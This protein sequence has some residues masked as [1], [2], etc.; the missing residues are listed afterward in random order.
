MSE[1]RVNL[2]AEFNFSCPEQIN[3][4]DTVLLIDNQQDMRLIMAHY[5]NKMGFK[6]VH[7]A[8]SGQDALQYLEAF[9]GN[10]SVI[11]CAMELPMMTGLDF[12]HEI[13]ED[14]RYNRGPFAITMMNPNREKIM[15]A[16]E[17]GVDEILVKPFSLKDILPKLNNAFKKFH[18]PYN[19]EKV[20]E[21]AKKHY[22]E[23]KYEDGEKIYKRLAESAAQS[24]RPIVGLARIA[25]KQGDHQKAMQLLAE[26][27]KRNVNYVHLY[28]LRGELFSE[29]NRLEEAIPQFRKAIEMSPL[30]PVRYESAAKIL[31]QQSKY[32]EA[33]DLLGIAIKNELNFP[34]LHHYLSQAFYA[35]KDFKRAIKHIRAALSIDAENVVYLNQLGIAY[36]ESEMYEDATKVYNSI[37]KLDPENKAALYNKAVLLHTMS[38]IEEAIKILQRLV[39]KYPDFKQAAAKLAEYEKEK[40]APKAAS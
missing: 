34:S 4:N 11:I 38:N 17:N 26:A 3:Q 40:S 14:P 12:L 30:N 18:N 25:A 23:G 39:K 37:I 13:K 24:A 10:I 31:F 5:L 21:L 15:F 2:A 9:K 19:P 1:E 28:V 29:L 33:A 22:R 8:V 36:K 6:N 16:T 7:Q 35:L 27:E 20:Y 32:Q